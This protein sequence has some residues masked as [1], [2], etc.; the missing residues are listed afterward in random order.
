MAE[1]NSIKNSVGFDP[2]KVEEYKNA[3]KLA[4]LYN[5]FLQWLEQNYFL[6][7][8]DDNEKIELAKRFLK[9]KSQ[10]AFWF[11]PPIRIFRKQDE[12]SCQE[13][14]IPFRVK[15]FGILRTRTF[16]N[17]DGVVYVYN[18]VNG[19]L[20]LS[21]SNED[22]AK[23]MPTGKFGLNNP[24][25]IELILPDE[26]EKIHCFPHVTEIVILPPSDKTGRHILNL[27]A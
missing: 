6:K 20:A 13:C 23:I 27:N 19:S 5:D 2:D 22:F 10:L 8:L 1:E 24:L 12:F 4:V 7:V 16:P 26:E 25:H 11:S 18:P 14:L 3:I 17:A 15:D 9:N 21:I